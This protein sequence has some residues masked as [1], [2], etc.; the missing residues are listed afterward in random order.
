MKVKD[1]RKDQSGLSYVG[2]INNW[3]ISSQSIIRLLVSSLGFDI[4]HTQT[5][6]A[7]LILNCGSY[8]II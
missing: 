8:M 5:A 1:G 6:A 4:F 2:T 7:Q 3:L